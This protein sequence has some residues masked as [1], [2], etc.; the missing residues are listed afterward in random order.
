MDGAAAAETG[1]IA[2]GRDETA[3]EQLVQ[4]PPRTR[5]KAAAIARA[6]FMDKLDS[7]TT[8]VTTQYHLGKSTLANMVCEQ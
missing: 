8:Y 1:G 6:G 4:E 2:Q 3:E 5:R 7:A